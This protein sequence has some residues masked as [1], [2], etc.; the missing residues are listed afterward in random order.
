M[1]RQKTDD[2]DTIHKATGHWEG[3]GDDPHWVS[4]GSLC[5]RQHCRYSSADWSIVT[6]QECILMKT[7]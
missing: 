1:D 6:C 2:N 4:D 3:D 5:G 7:D